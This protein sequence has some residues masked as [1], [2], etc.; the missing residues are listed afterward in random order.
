[1]TGV[2]TCALPIF[3][4]EAVEIKEKFLLAMSKKRRHILEED[5]QNS[6][7]PKKDVEKAVS[8]VVKKALE[9]KDAGKIVFPWET[10]LV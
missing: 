2:Q 10:T 8:E 1:V 7:Y 4:I 6:K 9:L 5:I 3:R